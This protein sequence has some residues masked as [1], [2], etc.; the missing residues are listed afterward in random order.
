MTFKIVQKIEFSEI[1]DGAA[2]RLKANFRKFDIF[3]AELLEITDYTRS[4]SWDF[5]IPVG[6]VN[7]DLRGGA[8]TTAKLL[9]LLPSANVSLNLVT[10]G[11]PSG[12]FIA[13]AGKRAIIHGEW[14]NVRVSNLSS[15]PIRIRAYVAGV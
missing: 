5:E 8:I 10:A 7:F 15:A 1:P 3:P 14:T 13:L 4:T 2:D 6:V 9:V 11:R 12:D